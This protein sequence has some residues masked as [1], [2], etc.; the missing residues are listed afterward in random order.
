MLQKN[1]LK[2]LFVDL[3]RLMIKSLNGS[4]KDCYNVKHFVSFFIHLASGFKKT[5]FENIRLDF[6]QSYLILI[7]IKELLIDVEKILNKLLL[8]FIHVFSQKKFPNLP[9]HRKPLLPTP[10]QTFHSCN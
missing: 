4:P 5:F 7:S 3:I 2:D 1:N 6:K 9:I 8:Y 10:F